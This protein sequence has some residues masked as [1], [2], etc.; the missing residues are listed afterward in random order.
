M[1]EIEVVQHPHVRGLNV[2]LD[3]VDYRA[4]HLHQELE[5]LWVLEGQL[6]VHGA[7]G[8]FCTGTGEFVLFNPK[9][10]HEFRKV[11]DTCTFLCVQV[12][13]HF[14]AYGFPAVDGLR[15]DTPL[16]AQ[17]LGE[18]GCRDIRRM[19]S[20]LAVSYFRR[21]LGCELLCAG[22]LSLIL[23]RLLLAV[24]HHILTEAEGLE[25]ERR[26]RRLDR[27]IDFVEENHRQ[28]ILLSDFAQQE[29]RSMSYLSHFVKENLGQSFQDY[30]TTVR[31]QTACA[32]IA[33]GRDRLLDVCTESGFSD[34]RY[35]SN[36]FRARLGMTP[37][38][39]RS[40][41]GRTPLE[42]AHPQNPLSL[43]RFYSWEESLRLFEA[44]RGNSLT[45]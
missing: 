39:Y 21:D 3:T 35:F 33:A 24:P 2:F 5:L 9:Q 37:E 26:A 14:F 1:R 38:A 22:I 25:Q 43:E 31:F 20:E 10:T 30:V 8:D 32:L 4:P 34:Y 23:R 18:D 15:F 36:A 16:P 40:Q 42:T 27:L 12:S 17:F 13:P 29:G 19:L 45:N 7:P 6:E 11:G 44:L 28:K 41:L